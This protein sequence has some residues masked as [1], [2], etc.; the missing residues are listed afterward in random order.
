MVERYYVDTAIWIDMY[1]NRKGFRGEP[2]GAFASR[3]FATILS[4][5]STLIITD[6]LIE[7]L[8]NHYSMERIN[9]MM[10]P[11]E[12]CIKKV[13]STKEQRKES[14]LLAERRGVPMGDALHA[15]LARDNSLTLITRDKDFR[16]LTDISQSF[17]PESLF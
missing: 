13:I 3:L 12:L 11:F 14:R 17:K 6:V 16:K 9:G 7:E 10:K 15:I 2:L 4:R 1:D 8:E 5:K